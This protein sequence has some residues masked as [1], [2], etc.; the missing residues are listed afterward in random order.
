MRCFSEISAS[1]P[2][3]RTEILF[4]AFARTRRDG[5]NDILREKFARRRYSSA[6]AKR[7]A[8]CNRLS[9]ARRLSDGFVRRRPFDSL[10]IQAI[11]EID[12]NGGRRTFNRVCKYRISE[13]SRAP[14][15]LWN[16]NR[17]LV[18]ERARVVQRDV[19]RIE[20]LFHAHCIVHVARC[21]VR[22]RLVGRRIV[23]INSQISPDNRL[24]S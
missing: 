10:R 16:N 17:T 6:R 7:H 21:N 1:N 24:H 15:A 2:I 5:D 19:S 18:R 3:D 22:G 8:A 13:K 4:P 11:P 20:R 12:S 9:R 23:T 14:S